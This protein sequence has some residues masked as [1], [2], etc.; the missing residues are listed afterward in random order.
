M[1]YARNRHSPAVPT[2][3]LF[4]AELPAAGGAPLLRLQL[5][6][7]TTPRGGGEETHLR[8]HVQ[9]SLGNAAL[10]AQRTPT[11]EALA[12]NTA[13]KAVSLPLRQATALVQR[14]L[15]NPLVQRFAA[16]LLRHDFNTWIDVRASTAPLMRGVGALMPKY[17]EKLQQIG[18]QLPADDDAVAQTWSGATHG[19][20][21]GF[22]QLSL[23]RLDKR[24]LPPA[25]AA[26]LGGAPFQAVA[27]IAQVVETRDPG[28]VTNSGPRAR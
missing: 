17:V 19:E 2:H 1:K 13:R 21:P 4:S 28:H 12:D 24:H 26:L 25:V 18:V 14:G 22:A 8:L 6:I 10:A 9:S 5:E 27:T 20:R 15:R 23:L 11:D 3:T 7:D 16:P